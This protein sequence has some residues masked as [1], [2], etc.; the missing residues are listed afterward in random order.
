M[1]HITTAVAAL[2]LAGGAAQAEVVLTFGFT[3]ASGAYSMGGLFTAGAVDD[4]ALSTSGDVTRVMAPAGT[5]EFNAGFAGGSAADF[6]LSLSVTDKTATTAMGT[7]EF[8]ITDADGDT[9]T[10][11]ISGDWASGGGDIVF[12]DGFLTDVMLN[13]L[14]DPDGTFDGPT[15]GAFGMDIAGQP[16]EGA[17]VSLFIATGSGFFDA[18]FRAVSTQVDGVVVPAPAGALALAG[19]GM[20]T[21][22]RRR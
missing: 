8:T 3:E 13:D 5:A 7:G 18:D 22:R 1:H 20:M 14:G 11:T 6:T 17:L 4:G 16:L 15:S 12:F 9:I 21:I 19:F 10:G 2:A